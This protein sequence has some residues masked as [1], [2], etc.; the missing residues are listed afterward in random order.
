MNELNIV[1]LI[2]KNPI[3]KLSKPYNNRFLLKIK[4]TF[5]GFEQQLFVSS[6]YCY[7]NY[8]KNI[9]FVVDLDN[10]W[11]WLGFTQKIDAKR[12]LEKQFKFDIDYK[13]ISSQMGESV[14]EIDSPPTNIVKQEEKWGGHNK[15][16][17]ML[18]IKCFKSL[19]LKA[20]TKKAS[21]IHEYYMKMEE[22]LHQIVEE[23]T[24]ELRLQLEEKEN[25]ILEIKNTTEQEKT[26]LKKEK[27]RAIEQ[28]TITQ[29]PLNTECIYFGTIDNTNHAK[30]NLIKFGHTNDLATRVRDHR[31][32]YDNFILTAAFRV[33]NKVEIENLIKAYP[34]IKRQIRTININEKTKTEIVAYDATNFTIEKLTKYIKDIIHSKTYSIDNFNRIMKENDNFLMANKELQEQI[35][36]YLKTITKQTLEINELKETINLQKAA[37]EL[38]RKEDQSVYS[39]ILLPEDENTKKFAEFI[40]TMCIV[41]SDVEESSTVMEGQ[42]RIWSKTKPKKETF[43]AL[44][45]YLDTRF[46]PSRISNQ[47]KDQLVHGY[48]GVK[49]KD[50]TY[51]KKHS[52]NDAETFLF[53]VC[54]FSPCGKMLNS[55][56]LEEYQRWKKSVNKDV[57]ENDMADLK[58]YLN[59]CEYVIKA[60][61]WTDKGSNE[62]Y[63]GVSLKSEEY[64]HKTTSSTGKSVEKREI[65][66]NVLLGKWETIA[67]AASSEGMSPAKMSRSIKNAVKFND[68]YFYQIAQ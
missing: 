6:F 36:N 57:S 44:K 2:E 30:E 24:D 8:D 43:H 22:T 25:V 41:R 14:S 45:N 38:A 40:D 5:T 16:I 26:K 61:V 65:K 32:Q 19:C 39:N 20:Q 68:D 15:Q 67:K 54:H 9:D 28:A 53:Q 62:G 21:E 17:I 10:I 34:K 1:D 55:T 33:Q 50:L 4:E 11:K 66:T 47:T 12:L 13:N 59:D 18:T 37:L 48:I 7:L 46:K 49:L 56:L 35:D 63:Y 58:K 52:D 27:Q 31:K 51:K 3:A 23:E 60:T 42:F 64:K 29:F